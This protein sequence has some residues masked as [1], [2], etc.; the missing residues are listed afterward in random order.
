M[1]ASDRRYYVA[2]HL[3]WPDLIN[4]FF[5]MIYIVYISVVIELVLIFSRGKKKLEKSLQQ[6]QQD[7]LSLTEKLIRVQNGKWEGMTF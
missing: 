7:I 3:S 6:S 1:A 2:C 5:R 4:S